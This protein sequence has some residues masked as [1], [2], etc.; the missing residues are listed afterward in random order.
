MNQAGALFPAAA[1]LIDFSGARV[2]G[3]FR[4]AL[5]A[6]AALEL[7]RHKGPSPF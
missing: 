3:E 7:E 6:V 2:F 1:A 5:Q 4:F